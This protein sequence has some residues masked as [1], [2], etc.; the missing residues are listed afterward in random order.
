LRLGIHLSIGQGL[1]KTMEEALDLNCN[2][3]QVF[4]KNPRSWKAGKFDQKGAAFIR[5]N[6]KDLGID[7]WVVHA[8]YLINPCSP[9]E[10]LYSRSISALELEVGR[11]EEMGAEFFVIHPGNSKKSSSQEAINRLHNTLN[12]LLENFHAIRFLVEGMAGAGTELGADFLE[13]SKIV[14]PF[15]P[16]KVGICLDT[17][18]LFASGFDIRSENGWRKTLDQF[19]SHIDHQRLGLIHVND[20]VHNLG[21]NKDRHTHLGEGEIGR[22]GFEAM[23][24]LPELRNIPFILETPGVARKE[25]K[26]NLDFLRSL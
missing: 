3:V 23:V 12:H 7:P 19:F 17:C 25:G 10:D 21:E 14:S 1:Q 26:R 20:S 16:G 15:D 24:K 18:H 2:T 22:Q 8:T 9:D 5:Q 6:K 4:A 13:L 11:A